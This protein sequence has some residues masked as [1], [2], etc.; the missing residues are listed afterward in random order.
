[1]AKWLECSRRGQKPG[2]GWWVHSLGVLLPWEQMGLKELPEGGGTAPAREGC[3]LVQMAIHKMPHLPSL[4]GTSHCPVFPHLRGSFLSKG[5]GYHYQLTGDRSLR[6]PSSIRLTTHPVLYDRWPW[7]RWVECSAVS[8]DLPRVWPA[9]GLTYMVNQPGLRCS[10]T[11]FPFTATAHLE[12]GWPTDFHG[13]AW[14][15]LS[16]C[17]SLAHLVWAD[18]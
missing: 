11:R 8:Q 17:P 5:A 3:F 13:S 7:P 12:A 9:A 4:D 6:S 16:R 10:V 2:S 18:H 15:D 14:R 1:M